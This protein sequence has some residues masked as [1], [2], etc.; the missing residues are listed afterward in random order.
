MADLGAVPAALD[1]ATPQAL[2]GYL[3]SEIDKW[4]PLIEAAGVYAD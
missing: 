2:R 3:K 4:G 1:Q